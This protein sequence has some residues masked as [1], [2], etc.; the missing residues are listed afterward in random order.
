MQNVLDGTRSKSTRS[1]AIQSNLR[2]A[3]RSR[4]RGNSDSKK[5][6]KQVNKK[7]NFKNLVYFERRRIL[8][9]YQKKYCG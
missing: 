8:L 2:T 3:N 1:K 4:V 9:V 7:Q 6:K 5:K